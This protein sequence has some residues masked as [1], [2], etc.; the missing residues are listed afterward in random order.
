M[1]C[2]L[3]EKDSCGGIKQYEQGGVENY[4]LRVNEALWGGSYNNEMVGEDMTWYEYKLF[5]FNAKLSFLSLE[6]FGQIFELR[7]SK[8]TDHPMQTFSTSNSQLLK[9]QTT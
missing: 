2:E 9:R 6:I 3:S 5:A 4:V 1:L 8:A 7:T